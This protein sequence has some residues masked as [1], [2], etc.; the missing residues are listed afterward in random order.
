MGPGR[1]GPAPAFSEVI[2]MGGLL[3]RLFPRS[4]ETARCSA[5]VAA[6]GA[7]SRMGGADKLFLP[8]FGVPVL[9]RTLLALED[10]A[11]I[12]E[13]VVVS[14]AESIVAVS[15][16]CRSFG[17]SKATKVLVGGA[18]RLES[19]RIGLS[20]IDRG[21]TLALIHD[22]A[23]PLVTPALVS[24]IVSRA[25]ETGAA[26]PA[27]PVKDTIKEAGDGYVRRTPDRA[28]L[29]AVQT[30]QVFEAS[31]IKGALQKAFDDGVVLTDDCSAVER[32]G[33]PVSLVEG[34]ER[35][36]KI[37]TRVDIIIAEALLSDWEDG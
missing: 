17:I 10:C 23:R 20:E 7:S 9:A 26:A 25:A 13:I 4:A 34:E 16:L 35:N 8:L 30:P 33:M 14:R 2:Q 15:D 1:C 28:G 37:T 5:V 21:A 22:G 24:R 3:G 27:L 29:C 19:V 18:T 11:E 12:A 31:L 32:L 36:L 6:A